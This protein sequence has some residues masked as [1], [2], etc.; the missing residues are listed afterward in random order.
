M[1]RKSV[2]LDAGGQRGRGAFTLMELVVAM[3]LM[4]L[5]VGISGFV[6]RHAV[7]AYRTASATSEIMRKYQAIT[8]QLETD[9]H[10][11]RK[12]GEFVLVWAP[13]PALN[14]SGANLDEDDNNIPDWYDSF[15]RLYFFS[16]GDFQTYNEPVI[17]SGVA[18]I[19]YIFGRNGLKPDNQNLALQ[20]ADYHKR[21]LCRTQHVITAD[22]TLAPFPNWTSPN[23]VADFNRDNFLLEYQTSDMTQWMAY[24]VTQADWEDVKREMI[25]NILDLGWD[26]RWADPS[27]GQSVPTANEPRIDLN[28]SQTLHQL[29]CQGVGQ[30]H[31]QIWRDDLNRWYPQIDPDH[32][33][34][35]NEGV[36]NPGTTDYELDD[37]LI[38]T[39]EYS[40]VAVNIGHPLIG[41]NTDFD[42]LVG[43]ALKFTF[44]LYDSLGIFPEGKTFT[45]IV[46]LN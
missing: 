27:F 38:E 36:G 32:D 3:S 25:A 40:G 37:D 10:G 1:H 31:V 5:L 7:K 13:S 33:G 45:H 23:F 24:N 4:A 28:G 35:Y 19:C 42:A 20:E 34:L 9:L 29:F 14:S 21:M 26:D 43:P 6:F 12:D 44:T 16:E 41:I 15:D 46:Y 30:F 8:S 18:R 11:L 17:H 39:G 22:D 2:Q